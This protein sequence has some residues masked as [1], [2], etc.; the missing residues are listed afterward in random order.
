MF[1]MNNVLTVIL[2]SCRFP[3]YQVITAGGLL[4]ADS[5]VTSYRRSAVSTPLSPVSVGLLISTVSGFTGNRKFKVS[6]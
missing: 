5:Q 6:A 2:F 1:V 4:P 3:L